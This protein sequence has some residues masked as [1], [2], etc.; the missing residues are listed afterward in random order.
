MV[1]VWILG[2]LWLRITVTNPLDINY[3]KITSVVYNKLLKRGVFLLNSE[4]K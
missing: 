2:D 4:G 3:S 1:K